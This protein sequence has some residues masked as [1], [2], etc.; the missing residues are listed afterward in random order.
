MIQEEYD[1]IYSD[2]TWREQRDI[3]IGVACWPDD[4]LQDGKQQC[5][6]DEHLLLVC[7]WRH[8]DEVGGQEK[9]AFLSSGI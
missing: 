1:M 6:T 4:V 2:K 8:G 9:K 7:T 3:W 5:P